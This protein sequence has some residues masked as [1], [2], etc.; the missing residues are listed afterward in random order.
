MICH[1]DPGPNNTVFSAPTGIPLAFIDFD[2]AAPGDPLEDLGYMAWTWCISSKPTAPPVTAQAAQVRTLADA[3]GLDV[4]S[5]AHLLDTALPRQLRNA[6][7]RGSPDLT[8]WTPRPRP[9]LGTVTQNDEYAALRRHRRLRPRTRYPRPACRRHR[10]PSK[11]APP[12][13]SLRKAPPAGA[14]GV[15]WSWGRE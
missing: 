12:K 1:H 4:T 9:V 5:R 15:G 13:R 10:L 14:S 8:R 7:L 3:Y 11:K 2:T 6:A